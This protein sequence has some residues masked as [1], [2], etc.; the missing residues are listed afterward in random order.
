MTTPR[1]IPLRTKRERYTQ[2]V[3]VSVA[4]FVFL[5]AL[6]LLEVDTSPFLERIGRLGSI[7]RQ[8]LVVD[9]TYFTVLVQG[10]LTSVFLAST[11]LVVGGFV[12]LILSFLAAR[13]IAPVLWIASL[14]RAIVSIIRAIPA[15]VWAL[16]VI[17]SFGFGNIGGVMTLFISSVGFLTKAF[18]T[19]IEDAGIDVIEAL[20]S[21][22]A[23]WIL[24]VIKGLIP[25]TLSSLVTWLA[26]RGESS[27]SES[28]S[29]GI[30]GVAGIGFTLTRSIARFQYGQITLGVLIIFVTMFSL[31]LF[32]QRFKTKLKRSL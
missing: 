3:S 32:T 21:T 23:P 29:L 30:I 4:V 22:G 13:N 10:M 20:R 1:L 7:V 19:S 27:V 25:V 11:S 5:T 14:I 8:F 12:A 16:M 31:E 28:I 9:M 18:V 6:W 26:V 2:L 24:I 15:L 17:A